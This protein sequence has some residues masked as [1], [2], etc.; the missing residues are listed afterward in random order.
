MGP[1]TLERNAL[2]PWGVPSARACLSAAGNRG[3]M[4]TTKHAVED[5]ARVD[6]PDKQPHE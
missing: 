5:A 1:A 3:G 4:L 6:R 2:D